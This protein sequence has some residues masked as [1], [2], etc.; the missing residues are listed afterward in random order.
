L[1]IADFTIAIGAGVQQ[2][3]ETAVRNARLWP[4]QLPLP[5]L[6][7]E[8]FD[9]GTHASIASVGAVSWRSTDGAQTI[10]LVHSA[11]AQGSSS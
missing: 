1:A 9:A 8:Q 10:A 2:R 3:L 6:Q 4:Q 11:S 5:E 7:A